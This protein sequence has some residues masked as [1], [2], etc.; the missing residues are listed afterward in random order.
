MKRKLTIKRDLLHHYHR[1]AK[2]FGPHKFMTGNYIGLRGD[3]S[4]LR[5]VCT[6]L[7]GDCSGLRGDCSGLRG[8]CSGIRGECTD[9]WGN[10]DDCGLTEEDRRNGVD[11]RFLIKEND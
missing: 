9:L 10:L 2:V 5:G 11:L 7:R 8:T 3:C 4:G 6:G 1:G